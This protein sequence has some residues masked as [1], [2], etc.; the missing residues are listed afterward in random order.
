MPNWR[1]RGSAPSD[2]VHILI[3]SLETYTL[4]T[5]SISRS[6]VQVMYS[7]TVGN[8]ASPLLALHY[9]YQAEVQAAHP[10][11]HAQFGIGDFSSPN[12]GTMGFRF[13]VNEEA[14]KGIDVFECSRFQLLI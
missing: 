3:N 11:F 6:S 4:A 12:F 8:D 7:K 13:A 1:S 9:D 2:R 14:A 5:S 10:L